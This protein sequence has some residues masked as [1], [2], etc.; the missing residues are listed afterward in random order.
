MQCACDDAMEQIRLIYGPF[1]DSEIAFYK[2]RLSDDGK[3]T[4]NAF[5][6]D[7]I[8][9]MFFKYF[10]DINSLNAI[11]IDDYVTLIIAAKRILEVSGMILLPYIISS[12]VVRLASR[13]N[14]NKKELVKLEASP[15]WEQV[16]NKYRSEKIEKHILSLIA[17]ILS[18]EFEIIDPDDD[19]LDGQRISV[20]PELV[21]EEV[22]MYISL[23]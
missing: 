2:D 3:C 9:N 21:C 18:S 16:K 11:N 20:I 14:I 13:K 6:R 17:V 1:D 15:L 5:Q 22:L 8:F 12:K 4:V 23:I 10:G 19:E 7:L